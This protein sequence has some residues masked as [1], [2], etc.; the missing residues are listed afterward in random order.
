VEEAEV[1]SLRMIERK[2]KSD[3]NSETFKSDLLT[4]E[5]RFEVESLIGRLTDLMET[6]VCD[7]DVR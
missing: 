3:S 4:F 6:I 1:H 5:R 7:L 2:G